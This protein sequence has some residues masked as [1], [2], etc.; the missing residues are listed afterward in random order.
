MCNCER[1]TRANLAGKLAPETGIEAAAEFADLFCK[2]IMAEKHEREM[3]T[4]RAD[5]CDVAQGH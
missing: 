5:D 4:Y 1:L 3:F 2:A